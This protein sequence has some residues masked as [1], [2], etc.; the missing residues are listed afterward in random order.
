MIASVESVLFVDDVVQDLPYQQNWDHN[1]A[2]G[3]GV[4]LR[5]LAIVNAE[6][7]D[8]GKRWTNKIRK[9]AENA[10]VA[11]VRVMRRLG[12]KNL[13]GCRGRLTVRAVTEQTLGGSVSL[14][15]IP[16]FEV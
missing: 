12:M 9:S 1:F 8:Q 7:K 3:P 5:Q 6:D 10:T 11:A 14:C 15:R 4:L 13:R 16:D 2:T